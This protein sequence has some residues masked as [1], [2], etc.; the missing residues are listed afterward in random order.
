MKWLKERLKRAARKFR[1]WLIAALIAVGLIA[2]PLL[3]AGTKEFTWTNPTE[4]HDGSAFDPA[5]ELA[6]T[7]IYCNGDRSPTFVVPGPADTFTA[8]LPAGSHVCYATAVD[9]D[10]LESDASNSVTFTILPARPK[11]P[12]LNQ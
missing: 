3:L 9:N 2:P 11:P 1:A 12:I 5:T 7:R 8:N 10:G 4:R 6:E